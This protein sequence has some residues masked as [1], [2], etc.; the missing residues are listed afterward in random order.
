MRIKKVRLKKNATETLAIFH[1]GHWIPL[2]PALKAMKKAGQQGPSLE[3]VAHDLIAFLQAYPNLKTEL[4]ALL[5]FVES[6]HQYFDDQIKEESL[7]PFQPLSFRDFSIWEAHFIQAKWGLIQR[8]LPGKAKVLRMY[9]KLTGKPHPKMLPPPMFY[10]VPVYYMGN[11]LQFYPDGAEIPWPQYSQLLDYELEIGVI[12]SRPLYNASP[13]EALDA[14]GGFT[15]INDFSARDQQVKEF[16][17]GPF[18]PVIK[19]KNFATSMAAEVVT[20]DEILPRFESLKAT[21]RVNGEV[22]G[23]GQT[24]NP[25]HSLGQMVAYASLEEKLFPGEILGTGTIPGCSGVEVDRWI[26]PGDEVLLE[27]EGLTTLQ[28]RIGKPAAGS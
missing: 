11:H 19:T 22:W 20:A 3:K 13:E 25:T 9:Q 6:E 27:V 28:N 4:D 5:Q 15:L 16:L 24:A 21:V 17:E 7:L 23:S 26:Q 2:H 18:G 8:F 10:Q 1:N 14:I 12:L